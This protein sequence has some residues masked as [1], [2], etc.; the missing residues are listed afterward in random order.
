MVEIPLI[1]KRLEGKDDVLKV[2]TYVIDAMFLSFVSRV[3]FN[4]GGQR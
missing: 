3:V 1:V 4:C 2:I